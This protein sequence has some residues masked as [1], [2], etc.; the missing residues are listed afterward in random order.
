MIEKDDVAA[1]RVDR[2]VLYVIEWMTHM[3]FWM[4]EVLELNWVD[5]SDI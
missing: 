4:N 3:F 2:M 5:A 1:K